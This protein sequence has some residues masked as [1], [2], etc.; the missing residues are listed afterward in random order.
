[1]KLIDGST[2][3]VIRH[4]ERQRPTDTLSPKNVEYP[5]RTARVSLK[6][7]YTQCVYIPP[8]G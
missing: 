3:P 8:I 2:V 6:L 7:R 5:K 1:M 4:Y